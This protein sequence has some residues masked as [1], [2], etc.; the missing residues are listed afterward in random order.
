MPPLE[1]AVDRGGLIPCEVCSWH[2]RM[3]LT[4]KGC[5]KDE[6]IDPLTLPPSALVAPSVEFTMVQPADGNGEAVA[7]LPPHRTLLSKLDVVGIRRR[8]A[9]D[10]AG[11]RGHKLQVF[12]VALTHWFAND[13]DRLLAKAD[14]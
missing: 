10:E 8:S 7:D 13:S 12:A 5:G 6:R 3:R 9:A 1:F 14:L 2:D 11:L 4:P